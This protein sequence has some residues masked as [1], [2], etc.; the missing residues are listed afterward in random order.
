MTY[1]ERIFMKREE[2]VESKASVRN[3]VKRL[4]F[5]GIAIALEL[6]LTILV[7][8]SALGRFSGIISILYHLAA[9]IIVL[10]LCSRDKSGSVKMPWIILIMAFPVLGV[11]FYLFVGLNKTTRHMR[12]KYEEVDEKLFPFIPPREEDAEAL[13][14]W[15]R[16]VSNIQ[17]YIEKYS[18]Y[19][20]YRDTDIEFYADASDGLAA[21][22]EEL[23]KAKEFI[24]M[25]Y[26]AIEDAESWHGIQDILA[27]KV[28]EG[29]E[30][31]VLYD[32]MG[33]LGFITTDFIKRLES[34][35]IACRVFNPIF[36]LMSLFLNNRDH[37]KIT[38]V[39]G[40]VGFTGGYNLANEYFNLTH[41][42]GEWKDTGV[43]ME[44]PAVRSLTVAFL[45]MWNCAGEKE[46]N[47][48]T[49]EKYF[50]DIPHKSEENGFVLPYAISP[51][52]STRVGEDVYAGLVERAENYVYI[53]TPYLIITDELNHIIGLAAKR[54]VDVRIITPGIPDK[55]LIYKV[56]R[57]FYSN[58][59]KNGVRIYEF[60]PGFCH[61]KQ[62]VTDDVVAVC[63]TINY[64]Y[65]S[66]YHHFENACLMAN[67][68]A[69]ADVKEDFEKTFELC[70]E[71]TED[72]RDDG[73]GINSLLQHILRLFAPL[74]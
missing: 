55:K 24:F 29:V 56:T 68:K 61:A 26:H 41:P 52:C 14:G 53:M 10:Y 40:R 16:S 28:K 9:L 71:V 62:C 4:I 2:T 39:D 19:P 70:R 17:S 54:G 7:L 5:A 23:K 15:N 69:V 34:V 58:L 74:M 45:E 64:D 25:E 63:G 1:L 50:P 3:G 8:S 73:S 32:D 51:M 33:S 57:S 11:S 37:R 20:V 67:A 43:R 35:G 72:Y 21:Q 59:V 38:V 49:F 36:P 18:G 42:F 6:V 31:R 48:K 12:K 46:G 66:L 30:V 60:T 65:R 13:R 44:G 22:K 27:E 47:D